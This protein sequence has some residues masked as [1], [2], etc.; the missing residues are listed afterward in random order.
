MSISSLDIFIILGYLVVIALVGSFTGGR[1]KSTHDYFM[2]GSNVPWWAVAFSIVAAETSS[3][4]FISIPG[5]AY[6]SNLNFLQLTAGY[7]LARILV[8]VFFLPAYKTGQLSTAYSFLENRFGIT[9]RRYA[10]MVFLLTRIAADGVRLFSTAIPLALIFKT[11]HYFNDWSNFEIYALAIAIIACVSL[12]Y[13]Y[14]G[15][16]K[17]VIWADVVQ[18]SI[19]IGGALMALWVLLG[20]DYVSLKPAADAGKLTLF[21]FDWGTSIADFFRKPYT[22]LGA[23]IGGTFLSM[24]SHGTDQ[25]IVQRLLTTRTLKDSQKAII[26]SGVLVMVQ[27]TLFL[28]IGMLLFSFYKGVPLADPSVPF[29]KADEIFPLFIIQQLP[30]GVKGIIIAGLFA[31]AMSTLAGSMSS[32]SSSVV[33]DLYKPRL[34]NTDDRK[35]LKISRIITVIA[36]VVLIFVAFTFIA[37]NQSVVEIALGIASITYGGLLGTFLLGLFFKRADQ[38]GAIIGFTAAII[39]MILVSVLPITGLIKPIIHWTWFVLLGTIV[40]IVIGNA[41]SGKVNR[42]KS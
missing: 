26:A 41:F 29:S 21:N 14:T 10:S 17:G 2:G 42:G 36:A 8:A 7:L 16:V 30:V 33:L 6:I 28:F 1:Q 24:A 19:Y 25:L 9:T 31:A 37:L 11:A 35:E 22:F 39:V 23:L 3:L 34:K 5:L 15:G 13:T 40:T 27:F 18:M 4:T 20:Y 38:K 32:L 12:I